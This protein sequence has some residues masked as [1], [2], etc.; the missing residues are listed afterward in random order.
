MEVGSRSYRIRLRYDSSYEID[1]LYWVEW[2]D[3]SDNTRTFRIVS[4][5]D[6]DER[7]H[8]IVL[9]ANER[10]ESNNN[11]PLYNDAILDETGEYYLITESGEYYIQQEA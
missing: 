11:E 8:E 1:Q 9:L 6:I 4:V 2:T 10:T 7:A 3:R 5:I